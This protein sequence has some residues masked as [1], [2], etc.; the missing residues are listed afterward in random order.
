MSLLLVCLGGLAGAVVRSV[1]EKSLRTGRSEN[2]SH[3]GAF[4]VNFVG[5]FLLG[6]LLGEAVS[7]H[8]TVGTMLLAGAVTAFSVFS[9]ETLRL[10]QHGLHGQA[11]LRVLAGWLTGTA[12]ATAAAF[13]IMA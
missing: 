9:H 4:A 10:L 13:L 12:A 2:A 3:W 5:C 8:L 1:T 7:L 11:A 6:L